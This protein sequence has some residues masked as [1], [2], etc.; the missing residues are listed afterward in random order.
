MQRA[1]WLSGILFSGN[2]WAPA[3][4]AE[5]QPKINQKDTAEV[6]LLCCCR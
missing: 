6:V 3:H 5:N 1:D 2:S 4:T